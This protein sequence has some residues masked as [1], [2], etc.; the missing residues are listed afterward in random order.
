M[1]LRHSSTFEQFFFIWLYRT[2]NCGN[3]I[4]TF[5]TVW[6]SFHC[7]F[8]QNLPSMNVWPLTLSFQLS[9]VFNISF[10]PLRKLSQAIRSIG[11]WLSKELFQLLHYSLNC[12]ILPQWHGQTVFDTVTWC[13]STVWECIWILYLYLAWKAKK[14]R[15]FLLPEWN[16]QMLR[17]VW[18]NFRIEQKNEVFMQAN[19]WWLRA[20]YD[21][22]GASN[23]ADFHNGHT[24]YAVVQS[25]W[26]VPYPTDP[27][28]HTHTSIL[29]KTTIFPVH[30]LISKPFNLCITPF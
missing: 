29:W 30:T 17:E 4:G 27:H 1:S 11:D 3:F 8:T 7:I 2:W 28:S 25:Q 19:L 15:Y 18:G 26:P 10:G 14:K 13:S 16:W 5:L 23:L 24:E 9:W 20:R 22:D 6:N 21:G 12:T